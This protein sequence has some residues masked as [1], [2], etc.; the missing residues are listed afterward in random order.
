MLENNLSAALKP[1]AGLILDLVEHGIAWMDQW[2][3]HRDTVAHYKSVV[4][5]GFASAPNGGR[6]AHYEPIDMSG[7]SLTVIAS[8][9]FEDVV[10]FAE[11]FLAFS[12]VLR[13]PPVLTIAPSFVDVPLGSIEWKYS[14][15][16]NVRAVI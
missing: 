8:A 15:V 1:R 2:K 13:L 4:S 3:S 11:D 14:L 7:R 5:S 16:P 9:M 12:Y 10:T 6:G